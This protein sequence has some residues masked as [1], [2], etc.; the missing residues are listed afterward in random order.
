MRYDGRWTMDD[1]RKTRGVSSLV[2]RPSSLVIVLLASCFMLLAVI[3]LPAVAGTSVEERLNNGA[4]IKSI[5]TP[6][7][8]EWAHVRA[9]AVI[10]VEPQV[11][12][13]ML[14]DIEGWP[15]WLP[16]SEKAHFIS[17]KAEKIITREAARDRNRVGEIDVRHPPVTEKETFAGQWHRTAIEEY[18]LIWPLKDEWVIRRYDFD[19]TKNPYKATWKMVAS[20]DDE[21]DGSWEIAPWKGGKS[22]LLK[23]YYR[24]KIK[25]GVPR[26][27]FRTAV[28]FV[29][30][31]MI[32]SLRREAKKRQ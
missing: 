27:V 6:A 17:R 24:V 11:L 5:E 23:Y 3:C 12:W 22:S 16:M 28:S 4:I 7:D 8:S 29:V 25:S 14:I 32:K 2:P 31:S 21:I 18:D 30:T 1:G 19:E 26:P 15:K 10:D 13:K 20:D 9:E